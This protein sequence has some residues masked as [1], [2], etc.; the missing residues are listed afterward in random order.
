MIDEYNKLYFIPTNTSNRFCYQR[1]KNLKKFTQMKNKTNTFEIYWRLYQFNWIEGL[2]IAYQNKIT[3]TFHVILLVVMKATQ[4]K[5]VSEKRKTQL[6]LT[7]KWPIQ[8]PMK[9]YNKCF[10]FIHWTLEIQSLKTIVRNQLSKS[11]YD[12]ET[13]YFLRRYFL[14]RFE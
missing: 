7:I 4:K 9:H 6:V 11:C 10:F 5:N 12:F 3:T 13:I 8:T 2:T 1:Q 14:N